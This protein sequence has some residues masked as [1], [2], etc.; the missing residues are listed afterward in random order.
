MTRFVAQ[1]E[2]E[3]LGTELNIEGIRTE[4][5]LVRRWTK[6]VMALCNGNKSVAARVLGIDRRSLYRRLDDIAKHERQPC[7]R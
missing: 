2:P 4:A 6:H 3:S 1:P 7:P 5:Q